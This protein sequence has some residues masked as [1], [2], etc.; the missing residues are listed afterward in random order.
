MAHTQNRELLTILNECI[1]ACEH[2]AAAC[3]GEADVTAMADCIRTD[4]DCADVCNLVARLTARGSVHGKHLLQECIEVCEAC[5]AEC[6]K[7]AHHMDHCREC[8]EAC[9]RCAEACRAAA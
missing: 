1:A 4:I 2:C 5:A 9:R 8:A 3:L 6:E 7:H